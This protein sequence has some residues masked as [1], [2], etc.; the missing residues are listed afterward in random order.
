MNN[1]FDMEG[2][3]L[4][5]SKITKSQLKE[6]EFLLEDYESIAKPLSIAPARKSHIQDSFFN[7]KESNKLI[8]SMR[9]RY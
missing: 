8:S 6:R 4:R 5:D 7:H 1:K 9:I 2:G 3:P